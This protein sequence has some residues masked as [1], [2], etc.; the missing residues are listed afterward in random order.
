[1]EYQA[2]LEVYRAELTPDHPSTQMIEANLRRLEAS[3]KP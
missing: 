3:R 2:A 1:V